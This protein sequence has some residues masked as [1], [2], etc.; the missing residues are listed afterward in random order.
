MRFSPVAAIPMYVERWLFAASLLLSCGAFA[1][2]R[3]ADPDWKESDAPAAPAFRADRTIP[4]DMP[5]HISVR[6]G[7]DPQTI[8]ITDDGIVRY[9]VVATASGDSVNASYEG[10]RCLT[11]EVKVYARFG[12]GGVWRAV[13]NPEWK[14]L[15]GNQP[16]PHA[17]AFARQGACEGRA[18]TGGTVANVVSRLK[19]PSRDQLKN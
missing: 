6:V 18:A 3:D 2:L 8:R 13:P 12:S 7:I 17:L 10:I 1:Q 9:V 19:A 4:L 16:S 14:P 11:S 5:R 15:N